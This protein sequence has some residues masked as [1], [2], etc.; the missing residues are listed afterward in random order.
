MVFRH[1]VLLGLWVLAWSVP[2]PAVAA[3]AVPMRTSELAVVT[4]QG[5]FSFTVEMAVTETQRGRG[6]Q[7]RKSLA[8]DAGMLFDFGAPEPAAMWMMNT[9]IP[10]DMI[11]VAGDGRVVNVE[12]RTQPG[13]L[14]VIRSAGAVRAVLEV[15]AGTAE[16]LGIEAGSR[17]LHPVFGTAER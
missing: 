15:N 4:E 12:A 7:Y 6:L 10:L 14:A 13:S 9:P 3:D 11:F 17:V 8:P 16:R 1:I 5:R 2:Q